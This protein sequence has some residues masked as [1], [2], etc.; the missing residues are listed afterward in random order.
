MYLFVWFLAATE[1]TFCQVFNDTI[2]SDQMGILMLLQ[3]T[4]ILISEPW[5]FFSDACSVNL[6][7]VLHMFVLFM[8]SNI[9]PFLNSTKCAVDQRSKLIKVD[10]EV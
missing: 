8:P 10:Q 1:Y 4:N 9:S 7:S 3:V 6:S 5:D 2:I